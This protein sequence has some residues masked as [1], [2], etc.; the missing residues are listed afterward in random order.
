MEEEDSFHVFCTCNHAVFLWKA[1]A[2]EW[3]L[4]Y[5]LSIIHVGR[6]WFLHLLSKLHE[7]ERARIMMLFWRISY[8][9]NEIVHAK[10][11]PPVDVFVR[12]LSSYLSSLNSIHICSS[13]ALVKGKM[14]AACLHIPDQDIYRV[15]EVGGSWSAPAV[16]R[17]K[18][19]TDASVLGFTAGAG[20]ILRDHE[21]EIVFSACRLLYA[22]DDVLEAELLAIREEISLALQWSILPIDVES[23]CLE[24]VNMIKTGNSNKSKYAFIIREIISSLGERNSYITHIRRSYNRVSHALANFGR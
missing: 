20:M 16:G 4:P 21:G 23:D 9:R 13:D 11:P 17:V 19:N 14:S 1:M 3:T 5:R 24:A 10:Q 18:L 6:D 7:E 22:C 8:V 2:K 12:F 15:D